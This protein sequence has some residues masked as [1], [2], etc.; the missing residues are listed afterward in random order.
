MPT[1]AR[2][3]EPCQPWPQDARLAI[4][5]GQPRCMDGGTSVSQPIERDCSQ[6]ETKHGVS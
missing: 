6:Y 2:E 4:S 3:Q 5:D 1:L